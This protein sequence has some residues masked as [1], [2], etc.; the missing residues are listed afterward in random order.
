MNL[1][2]EL[3][4]KQEQHLDYLTK[5]VEE[6]GAETQRLGVMKQD[7]ESFQILRNEVVDKVSKA[8]A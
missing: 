2:K 6:L 1:A 7:E 4:E 8:L 3:N 5:K